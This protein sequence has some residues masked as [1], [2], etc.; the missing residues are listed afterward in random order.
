MILTGKTELPAPVPRCAQQNWITCPNSILCTTNLTWTR[1][2]SNTA[3]RSKKQ[4]TK[5]L[6]HDTAFA[7][8]DFSKV[9][10]VIQKKTSIF[11]KVIEKVIVK[12]GTLYE[13]VSNYQYSYQDRAIVIY[14]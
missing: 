1:L 10:S 12:K 3:L 11:W 13:H 4:A 5:R 8:S 9:H 7:I 2:G 6:N 14:K